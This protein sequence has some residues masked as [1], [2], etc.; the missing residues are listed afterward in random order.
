VVVRRGKC[1]F[2]DKVRNA[3]AAGADSVVVVDNRARGQ[4]AK[5]FTMSGDGVEDVDIPA[6]FVSQADGDTLID[7]IVDH[8]DAFTVEI[9][10]SKWNG[11]DD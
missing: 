8:G 6:V 10:S 2:I 9:Y 7:T 5:L 4:D 3:Q 11:V 1:S